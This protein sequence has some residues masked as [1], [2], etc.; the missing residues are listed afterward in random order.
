MWYGASLPARMIERLYR[1]DRFTGHPS[2]ETMNGSI[3]AM[4]TSNGSL[5]VNS[6]GGNTNLFTLPDDGLPIESVAGY[7]AS[8]YK[9]DFLN[10]SGYS[11]SNYAGISNQVNGKGRIKVLLRKI[12]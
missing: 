11:S 6:P 10:I 7:Q 4:N 12:S 2:S 3:G 1:M 9:S 8:T 5:S